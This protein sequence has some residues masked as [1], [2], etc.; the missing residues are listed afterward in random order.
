MKVT[1]FFVAAPAVVLAVSLYR[2]IEPD[3]THARFASGECASCHDTGPKYHGATTWP[4]THGRSPFAIED[5]CQRCHAAEV[6]TA[7]HG[8]APATHTIG[9][10][11]PSGDDRD[12]TRHAL[13][14]R[15]RPSA[16]LV[17]HADVAT[18]CGR[19][20]GLADLAPIVERGLRDLDR[21]KEVLGDD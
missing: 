15:V 18:D 16:C 10:R 7:C 4:V 11:E 2:G 21:W 13:L 1:L 3:P 6:C 19:C 8:L 9:F 5:R 20:H 14:A 17:C 12:A